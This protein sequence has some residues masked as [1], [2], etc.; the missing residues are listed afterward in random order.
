MQNEDTDLQLEAVRDGGGTP[1]LPSTSSSDSSSVQAPQLATPIQPDSPHD[2]EYKGD[3]EAVDGIQHR[4]V[5]DTTQHHASTS[6]SHPS[7]L[8]GPQLLTPHQPDTP[9][10]DH[11][12]VDGMQQQAGTSSQQEDESNKSIGPYSTSAGIYKTTLEAD[13]Q[14]VP[15]VGKIKNGV[16]I[17]LYLYMTMTLKLS[18]SALAKN[19][20]LLSGCN[21]VKY[22]N[23][24]ALIYKLV[25]AYRKVKRNS[26]GDRQ[27]RE[28]DQLLNKEFLLVRSRGPKTPD[29][30]REQRLRET[31]SNLKK[32]TKGMKRKLGIQETRIADLE[33]SVVRKDALVERLVEE[34][35]EQQAAESGK[36]VLKAQLKEL[37]GS[38][39]PLLE[40]LQAITMK[41]NPTKDEL[42]KYKQKDDDA[43]KQHEATEEKMMKVKSRVNQSEHRNLNKKL[44]RRD[45]SLGK[46]RGE[47]QRAQE[48]IEDLKDEIETTKAQLQLSRKSFEDLET[49]C[50]KLETQKRKHYK[51]LWK[52][53]RNLGKCEEQA[54]QLEMDNLHERIHFLE[55][56]NIE[57]QQL[58]NLMHNDKIQT[59]ADGRFNDSVHLT[60]MELLACNVSISKIDTVIRTVLKN[61]AGKEVDRLPSMETKSRILSEARHLADVEVASAMNANRPG[62]AIG[63]CI[64]G[65]GTTKYLKQNQE[66][67]VTLPDGTSRTMSLCEM[68]GRDTSVVSDSFTA[69]VQELAD[70][71]S[72]EASESTNITQKIMTTLKSTIANQGPTVPQL[73]DKLRL[74][75][76][77]LLPSVFRKWDLLEQEEKA[78][79]QQFATLYCK[80]HPLINFDEE[81]DKILKAY[82][83]IAS[84]GKTMHTLLTGESGVRRLIRTGSK[85][86]HHRGCEESGVEDS[87]SSYIRHEFDSDN[88]LVD[89]VGNRAY[90]LFEGA[91]VTFY[92][93]QH[94]QNFVSI[95]PEPNNLLRAV[96][97]D[98][99]DRVYE[100]EMRALGI[101]H[102]IITEPFWT[103]VKKARN[104]LELSDVLHHLQLKLTAW[105]DDG[106]DMLSGESAVTGIS[107]VK[108]SVYEKLFID[109]E[110]ADKHAICVQALELICCAILQKLERQCKDHLPGGKYWK[111]SASFEQA[112]F[113]VPSTNLIGERDFAILDILVRQ[114]PSA[115]VI[116]LEA[117]IIWTNNKTAAWLEDLDEERRTELMTEARARAPAVLKK[118]KER[119]VSIK[120]EKWRLLQEKQKKKEEKTRKQVSER[121]ALVDTVISQG[122]IWKNKEK[123]EEELEKMKDEDEESVRRAIYIQLCFHQRVLRLKGQPE[124][125]QLTTTV[126]GGKKTFT[127]QEMKEHLLM[128]VEGNDVSSSDP[129]LLV[130]QLTD[131]NQSPSH[132]RNPKFLAL[133]G[134]LYHKMESDTKKRE[135]KASKELLESFLRN[136]VSLV[137]KRIKHKCWNED[138]TESMWYAGVVKSI[139]CEDVNPLN[140]EYAV[141]YDKPDDDEEDEEEQDWVFD[142][143]Q[144]LEKND[145]IVM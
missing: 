35:S 141:E 140:T 29:T 16:I 21:T 61:L 7:P 75:K 104:I 49:K 123:I 22:Q 60:I 95:L 15:V 116:S 135:I 85:A 24:S 51:S 69:Q 57:L 37:E 73:S 55:Q 122:G 12:A 4:A 88:L 83:D 124:I 131:D 30:P 13:P 90:I 43:K 54:N 66:L 59:F 108:D 97:E 74:L 92:H 98:A 89:Y 38:H 128:V 67:Q 56:K 41:F 26:K 136:P 68:A 126:D 17:E 80:M 46:Y 91:A 62:D 106:G 64:H 144:D 119:M 93:L 110:D 101:V 132:Q 145:L 138:R 20:V 3:H 8:Q 11:E 112:F 18:K 102:K 42:T 142:L 32:Q 39:Q 130:S 114:K 14:H 117:L 53:K 96:A 19:V 105:K 100:A 120:S 143:L 82:E 139:V 111:P 33:T 25:Q 27:R 10:G 9:Q 63:N 40:S 86:F 34:V 50:E 109:K 70:S 71:I 134:K 23:V 76:E 118:Y 127:T 121:V 6:F 94:F 47:A 44:K 78:T 103:A 28:L 99:A 2:E 81:V 31:V 36:L 133:K 125:F 107:P 84:G 45:E 137:G 129:D 113:K 5:D 77:E 48:T 79:C 72:T 1:H 65:D 58:M 87:F 115:R 52:T